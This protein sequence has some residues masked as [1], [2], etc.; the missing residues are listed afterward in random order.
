VN[1]ITVS[2]THVHRLETALSELEELAG[3]LEVHSEFLKA[4]HYALRLEHGAGLNDDQLRE[5]LDKLRELR[6][7][8]GKQTRSGPRID[9]ARR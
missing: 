8:E 7:P 1:S 3:R 6:I 2:L 4:L 5:R 9:G